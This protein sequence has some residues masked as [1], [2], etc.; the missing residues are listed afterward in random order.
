MKKQDLLALAAAVSSFNGFYSQR[1]SFI[2]MNPVHILITLAVLTG[3][4]LMHS[5]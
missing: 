4:V 3:L 1:G 2:L 5:C